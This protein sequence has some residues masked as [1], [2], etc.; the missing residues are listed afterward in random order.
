MSNYLPNIEDIDK[1][2]EGGN[3]DLSDV[4]SEGPE[5]YGEEYEMVDI[6]DEELGEVL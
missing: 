4:S 6:S 2:V 3:R 1:Y 5:G